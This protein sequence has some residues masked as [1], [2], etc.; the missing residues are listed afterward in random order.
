MGRTKGTVEIIGIPLDLGANVRGANMGPSAIR[1][2]GLSEKVAALGYTV[3]EGGDLA[4]PV[5]ETLPSG[6]RAASRFEDA[7]FDV[8]ETACSRVEAALKAER[9]PIVVGGDHSLAIG[10]ISG[11]S[12]YFADE[13][14]SF[15]L[16]WIDAHADLNTHATSPSGNLHGMPLSILLGIDPGRFGSIGGTRTKILPGRVALIG[17]RMVDDHEKQIL[18]Q[19]GIRYF[20]MREIDERG[21]SAVMREALDIVGRGTD[22]VH[23]SFDL[24]AID[25]MAA[26]GVSTPA[27][28][29]LTYREA[30]LAMEMVSDT[31]LLSSIEVVELNPLNDRDRATAVLGIELVQSALGKA[32]DR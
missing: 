30:H 25:P 7:I 29:G 11:V 27:N 23:V 18:T 32:I 2:A 3:I 10:T 28:G 17:I 9:T 15:G 19:S 26:P 6:I 24:D 14:S 1:I 5:R 16:I 8:C 20:T 13:G 4:V 22:G 31:N 12:K 21:M